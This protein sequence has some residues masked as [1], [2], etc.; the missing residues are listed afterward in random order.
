MLD[1]NGCVQ[2]C[3]KCSKLVDSRSQ[4]VN[5]VGPLNARIM[6]IGEAPGNKEDV[7]GEPFVGKSGK[8]LTNKLEERGISR[9]S[10]RITN[11][12]RCTPPENRDPTSEEL[13]NC[14]PYLK[15]EIEMVEP[16]LIVT[17]G[18][19][20]SQNLLERDVK[21]TS[22]AGNIVTKEFGDHTVD[23]LISVHPAS[24]SYNRSLEST[25]NKVLNIVEQRA[26]TEGGQ[27]SLGQ[28]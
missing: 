17:L 3:T 10:V 13:E 4:I 23:V 21:V 12:A 9:D 22:E 5:G 14:K 1:E 7:K 11:S 20:P 6:L 2:D 26:D 24:I 25:L 18:K 15:E 28:F 19:V 16:E 8:E 27:S